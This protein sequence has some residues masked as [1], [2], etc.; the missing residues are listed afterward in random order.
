VTLIYGENGRGK[1]TLAAVLDSCARNQPDLI[2]RRSTIDEDNAAPVAELIFAT[3]QANVTFDNGAWSSARPDIIVFDT[4]FVQDNVYTGTEITSENRRGLYEFALGAAARDVEEMN[5]LTEEHQAAVRLRGERERVVTGH[6]GTM[7]RDEF[8]ALGPDPDIDAKLDEARRHLAAVTRAAQVQARQDLAGLQP[9]SLDIP[10]IF[11]G[12]ARTV[13]HVH[14]DAE[15]VVMAHFAAHPEPGFEDWASRGRQYDHGDSCP[16]CG[17]GTDGVALLT[18]YR[19][20]FS[21][22]YRRLK[23]AVSELRTATSQQLDARI[24]EQWAAA[25]EANRARQEAWADLVPPEALQL[26]TQP[27]VTELDRLRDRMMTLLEQKETRPLE[28]LG[29]AAQQAA[30]AAS[31]AGMS[32]AFEQ[33]NAAVDRINA[34]YAARKLEVADG[35]VAALQREVQHL[36]LL[37]LRYAPNVVDDIRLY[38]EAIVQAAAA[39]AAKD[40]ARVRHDQ[41]MADT[42]RDFEAAIN[43]RLHQLGAGFQIV[44]LGGN[45]AAGQ[46]PRT[47]YAIELRGRRVEELEHTEN[48]HSVTTAL[49]DGDRRSLALAFFLARLDLDAALATRILVFDDPMTSFDTNRKRETVRMLIELANRCA[50]VTVLSHDA[51]FL[52][53]IAQSTARNGSACAARRIGYAAN[54]YSVFQDCDLSQ[55]CREPYFQRFIAASQ[56]LDGHYTGTAR[57]VAEDLRVLVEEYYKLRYPNQVVGHMTLGNTIDAIRD[58]PAQSPLTTLQPLLGPLERLNTYASPYHHS[59]PNYRAEVVNEA[60]LRRYV[61]GAL[62]LVYDDGRCHPIP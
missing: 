45:Y 36:E 25:I 20:Y 14:A 55:L 13:E 26:D 3:G 57:Q 30:I 1:S 46:R 48:G 39:A 15:R 7:A 52:H 32:T 61:R 60:E 2:L 8:T 5:R 27:A 44:D 43:R 56:Y 47:R 59:N 35:D 58:A 37:K 29:D 19:D 49:S 33:Y 21:E 50:Q 9:P 17:Q 6:A 16:Y 38:G 31:L 12:L 28:A 41:L 40:T 11:A 54:E 42:F 62:S 22:A 23:T 18:A 24:V 10:T 34:T 53:D 51:H 4:Q